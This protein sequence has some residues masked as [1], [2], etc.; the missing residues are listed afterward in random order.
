MESFGVFYL[1]AAMKAGIPIRI[2]HSHIA[3]RNKGLKGIAK[4][5]LNKN[6]GRYATHLLAC[7][8]D[9]GRFLFGEDKDY[10]V[11]NN[12][13]NTESFLFNAQIRNAMRRHYGINPKKF[14]IG[15]VGRFDEQK[16]HMFLIDIFYKLLKKDDNAILILIGEGILESKIKRKVGSLGLDT[17][18]MFM[19]V[20]KDV[21]DLYQMM[22]V[23]VMPS[24]FEG[25]PISGIE[26]Q[27]AGLGCIFSD[28]ITQQIAI[29]EDV[30]F[31][32]LQKPADVWADRVLSHRKPYERKNRRGE[33]VSAGY[34]ITEQAIRLEQFYENALMCYT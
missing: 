10:E 8:D 26:A 11:F 29:T 24:L 21:A 4:E 25:L 18:V 14:V 5:L 32:S 17:K 27:A 15:H 22:D 3:Q 34:D 7:S 19:G 6:F 31:L 12:A 9:A 1:K 16:N 30:E 23:F 28:T 20:R 2:A 13:I 33:I